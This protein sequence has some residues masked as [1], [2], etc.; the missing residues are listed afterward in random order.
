MV[1]NMSDMTLREI[2]NL[3]IRIERFFETYEMA[4]VD[5]AGYLSNEYVDKLLVIAGLEKTPWFKEK[6][7]LRV[8]YLNC[9]GELF[10]R[11]F[12][13]HSAFEKFILEARKQ[14]PSLQTRFYVRRSNTTYEKIIERA[15]I[16]LKPT[17]DPGAA[18]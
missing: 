18:E 13:S 8:V 2:V 3:G 6:L 11:H 10:A 12:R 14:N 5:Y 16:L 17:I 4:E 9:W 15:K 1:P 7:D